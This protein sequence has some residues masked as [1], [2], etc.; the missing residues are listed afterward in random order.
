MGWN[1]KTVVLCLKGLTCLL[2][3]EVLA[4]FLLAFPT[5]KMLFWKDLL[6]NYAQGGADI[7]TFIVSLHGFVGMVAGPVFLKLRSKIM[8]DISSSVVG[9]MWNVP[10]FGYRRQSLW[11]F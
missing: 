3:K 9:V 1:F 11:Y 6:I 10:L 8:L 7:T 2:H 5:G 4:I